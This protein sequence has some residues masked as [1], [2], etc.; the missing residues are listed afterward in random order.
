MRA[1][2][3]GVLRVPPLE[4]LDVQEVAVSSAVL[5]AAAHHYGSQCDRPN[6]EFMLCRWKEK[7]PRKCLREGRQVN[8]CAID[9]FRSIR[10]HCAEP[11]TAYW[12]CIDNSSQQE[13][14]R[15]RKQQAAFHSCVLDKLGWVRPDLGDLSKV[16]SYPFRHVLL[17]C[18]Y[19]LFVQTRSPASLGLMVFC[20][21]GAGS[22]WDGRSQDWQ[23]FPGLLFQ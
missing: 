9:F 3:P 20:E 17:A 7:D 1:A 12:T 16:T 8:Q 10:T 6:K 14:R 18:L 11:F 13:L 22:L 5:K 19:A 4:E 15:C 23:H 21:L 2:M